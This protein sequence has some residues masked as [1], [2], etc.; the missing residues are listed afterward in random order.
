MKLRDI[1]HGFKQYALHAVALLLWL[2]A[3][4]LLKDGNALSAIS[5][6]LLGVI[7][8]YV[9]DKTRAIHINNGHS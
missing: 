7:C 4:Y 2:A 5:L 1:R 6:M 3:G 8:D 9:G